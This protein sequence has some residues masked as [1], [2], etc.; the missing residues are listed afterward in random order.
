VSQTAVEPDLE[1]WLA[2]QRERVERTLDRHLPPADTPPAV[3]HDAMRYSVLAGGKRI[4]PILAIAAAEAC[5]ADPEPLLRHLCAIELI[6]TYSLIHDDLPALDDD[7]LRRGRK[8]S[9]VVYGEAIAILAG[10]ALL[11]E[12]FSWLSSPLEQVDPQRQLEAL[13]VVSS[14]IDSRG[15][16]GGQVADLEAERVAELE[17]TQEEL[18]ERLEFIHSNKTGRLLTAAVLL[19]GLIGGADER[20]LEALGAYGNAI[21]LAFQIIDDLLDMEGTSESLGKTA[22]KDLAQGKLTYPALLG[23]ESARARAAELLEV[24]LRAAAIPEGQQNYLGAIARY[25]CSR[26]W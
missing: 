4:R 7:E 11:T 16:I 9:H 20:Q 15:M 25:V 6:H 2:G 18:L 19:G 24:A 10:D 14:A 13:R 12:A 26:T 5:G 23:A 21:G 17:L 3:I 22:G 1:P 8:T